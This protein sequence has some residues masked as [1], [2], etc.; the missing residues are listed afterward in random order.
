VDLLIL[1]DYKLYLVEISFRRDIEKYRKKLDI[2]IDRIKDRV[3][4]LYLEK[5]IVTKDEFEDFV[6]RLSERKL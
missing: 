3:S 1:A 5:C 6:N 2:I 4:G